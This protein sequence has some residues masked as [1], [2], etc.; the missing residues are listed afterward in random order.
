MTLPKSILM[1]ERYGWCMCP[2]ADAQSH[3]SP[4]VGVALPTRDQ[5]KIHSETS[6]RV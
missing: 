4:L 3:Y 6:K 5:S 2:P 1:G